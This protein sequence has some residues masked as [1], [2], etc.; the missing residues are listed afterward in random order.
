MQAEHKS[1]KTDVAM[2]ESELAIRTEA[3]RCQ[4]KRVSHK[5][6]VVEALSWFSA[7]LVNK[8][9]KIMNIFEQLDHIRS[10]WVFCQH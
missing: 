6:S 2:M 4:L 9:C 3:Y 5:T 7:S 10:R 1:Y 8:I